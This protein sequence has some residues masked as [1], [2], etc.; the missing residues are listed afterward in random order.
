VKIFK[1]ISSIF[2]LPLI[3]LGCDRTNEIIEDPGIPPAVPAG[4]RIFY[5]TDG[6]II[7]DWNSN[8]EPDVKGYNIYRRT[9]SNAEVKIAFVNDNYF[10][11]DS[12]EYNTTYY[13]KITAVNLW[14]RESDFSNEVSAKPENRN[15]P[16]K[17]IGL[18]INARNWEGELSVYIYWLKNEESDVE[19]YNIYR[20]ISPDFAPDSTNFIGFTSTANFSDTTSL[21]FYTNY[22]YK[23]RAKDKGGLL[24][25][26]SDVVND[27]IFE[28]P[29]II[30]PVD[31]S[32]VEFFEEFIIKTINTPAKYRIGLQT[33]KF[34]GE[35]WN[36]I[37]SST[38]VNDTLKISF[39]P[40][41]LQVNKTYYWRISTYSPNSSDPN[42]ISKL[43]SI[44]FRN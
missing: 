14:D 24:S 35:I 3:Y 16:D 11:D 4:L 22:Y 17:P 44:T 15:N 8:S 19:G 6:E 43:F 39:D 27:L 26:A 20:S 25:N 41:L 2:L 12:L 23:I 13:Y 21:N 28:I 34:F 7:I 18:R 40:P 33:N 42:S 31:S 29:E 32:T 5:A 36:T 1:I 10:F 9:E 37:V 38:I 30:F